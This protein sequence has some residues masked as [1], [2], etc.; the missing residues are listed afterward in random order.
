MV[1]SSAFLLQPE[2]DIGQRHSFKQKE[3]NAFQ[4]AKRI[5]RLFFWIDKHLSTSS[6]IEIELTFTHI[7]T[8][9]YNT[10][11]FKEQIWKI[12]T[13]LFAP[14]PIDFETSHSGHHVYR[15]PLIFQIH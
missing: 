12:H 9:M 1:I 5:E 7:R 8:D 6:E 10:H 11:A 3:N 13:T 4:N 15:K 2:C 14:P